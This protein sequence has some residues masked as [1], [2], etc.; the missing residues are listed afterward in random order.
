MTSKWMLVDSAD[1]EETLH[2]SCH[3]H[4]QKPCQLYICF[5]ECPGCRQLKHSFI[6]FASLMQSSTLV[7]L[8]RTV[9]NY[10][11]CMIWEDGMTSAV[12]FTLMIKSRLR[13]SL[14]YDLHL[15][16]PHHYD[17]V[18]QP[19]NNFHQNFWVNLIHES[20][21]MQIFTTISEINGKIQKSMWILGSNNRFL[22][23]LLNPWINNA[24]PNFCC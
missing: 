19:L 2:V 4:S 22:R 12:Q 14:L 10:K 8:K 17:R 1:N 16:K 6:S 5:H 20:N 24:S 23:Y 13:S 18:G 15:L 3:I 21:S 9:A 11:I 7:S